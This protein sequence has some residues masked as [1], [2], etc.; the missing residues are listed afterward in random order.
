MSTFND[1]IA[2]LEGKFVQVGTQG[3]WTDKGQLQSIGQDHL[4][5]AQPNSERVIVVK[6]SALEYIKEIPSPTVTRSAGKVAK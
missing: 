1:A 3:E 6:I 5:L 4:V 2:K